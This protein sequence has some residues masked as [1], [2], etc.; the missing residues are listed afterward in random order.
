VAGIAGYIAAVHAV[1]ARELVKRFGATL[2]IDR[3]DITI[4]PGEVRGLLGP[5]G[6]GKTTLLRML[7][8]LIR[9]DAG[10]IELLG[11]T[12]D[13]LGGDALDAVGGFVE[14]PCFYPYLSGR[15]N[16][17]L[18]AKLDGRRAGAGEIEDALERVDLRGR[19]DDR[20]SGYSN[21]MRQRLGLAAALLRSPRLLLLDEPTSGLDPAGTRAVVTLVRELAAEGVAVLLSSH[22]IG[23]LERL[24][25]SYTVLRHGKVVWDGTAAELEAQAPGSAYVLLTSDDA[26]ALELASRIRGVRTQPAARG[27]L[28]LAA[29]PDRMDELVA[30]LAD[31]RVLIRRLELVVSPLES[32]FFALTTDHGRAALD[33]LEPEQ[34]AD[35]ILTGA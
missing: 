18:L 19:A 11:H 32:M 7:F 8:G 27:G 21:G 23:E 33:A 1:R 15:S 6:V 16:L 30:A 31:A 12:L 24:C 4:G 26:Q 20:V 3:L 35:T 14:E 5:N 28:A 10:T 13:H 29:R 25:D 22:H 17:R 34:L 9:P 2:A